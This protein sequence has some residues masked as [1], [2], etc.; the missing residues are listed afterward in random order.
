[1]IAIVALVM[2]WRSAFPHVGKSGLSGSGLD[3]SQTTGETSAGDAAHGTAWSV[4]QKISIPGPFRDPF[5]MGVKDDP[6][7]V[8]KAPEPDVVDTVHLSAI[9][10]QGGRTL[11]VINDRICQDGDKI[12]RLRIESA[13]RDGVWLSHWKG[14]NF[15]SIGGDFSLTTPAQGILRAV[16]A[17]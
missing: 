4:V 13:T 6:A 7:A 1:M 8:E 10:T 2:V 17:L 3:A 16:G 14:R 9:W 12:G 15:V 5:A 11:V